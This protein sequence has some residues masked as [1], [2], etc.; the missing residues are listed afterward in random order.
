MG[1]KNLKGRLLLPTTLSV[2]LDMTQ[3][4]G[5]LEERPRQIIL[6]AVCEEEIVGENRQWLEGPEG[7]VILVCE[8]CFETRPTDYKPHG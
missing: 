8:A 2:F 5:N 4:E 1:L 7:E 6:C 3:Q